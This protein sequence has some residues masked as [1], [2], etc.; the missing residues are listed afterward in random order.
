MATAEELLRE[1]LEEEVPAVPPLAQEP[2][3]AEELGSALE[4]LASELL[5]IGTQARGRLHQEYC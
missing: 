1:R 2:V 4:V 5:G 3:P